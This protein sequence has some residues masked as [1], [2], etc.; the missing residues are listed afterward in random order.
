[1]RILLLGA[2]MQARA[3]AHDLLRQPDLEHLDVLEFHGPTLTDFR[4]AFPD[5]R[6]HV[7]QGDV[8]DADLTAPLFDGAD[9]CI[10]AVNYWYNADLTGTAIRHGCHFLDLGGNNDVVDAQFAQHEAA[11]AAG[12]TV[13]P[14]CGLA[15]GLAGLLGWHLAVDHAWDTCERVTLRVGGLPADPQP[16]LDYMIVFAVQGLINEYIEPCLVIRDGE[17]AVVPGMSELETLSFDGFGE[18]EAFQTSGGCST[19]PRTLLGR[20]RDMDYKTIRYPG[21]CEKIRLMMEV[22]LTGNDPVQTPAGDVRPRDLLGACLEAACP[23]TGPDLV[24][25]RAEAVGTVDGERRRRCIE[26]VDREDPETG[27]TAMMR[28]TGFPAAILAAM[29]ARGEVAEAGAQPQELV[30]PVAKVIGELE[31]RGIAVKLTDEPVGN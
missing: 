25:L 18:L 23:K 14:D 4:T 20:V 3:I 19:L 8:R 2:G 15:P 17:Q 27:L 22:G 6:I 1:M 29:L 13:L 21:H 7:H 9:A 16:P 5:E 11:A 10:S 26:I 12:V 31:R 28:M 24:L 30:V